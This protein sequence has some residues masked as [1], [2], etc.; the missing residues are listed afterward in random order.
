MKEIESDHIDMSV[1]SPPFESLYTYTPTERDL[2]NSKNRDEFIGH[3]KFI[4]TELLRITKPGRVAAVHVADIPAM[5][6]RDGYIGLKDFSG[7]VIRLFIEC[8][9]TFDSRIPIDKNQ[10]AQ[11]IRTHSKAL[12][13][14]QLEKDRTWNRPA[15]PDYILKFRKPGDNPVP[16][17]DKGV[18][19]D[20]WIELAN[21]TWP[22]KDDRAADAGAF[23]TWYGIDESDTLNYRGSRASEDERHI[24]P[25]QLGTIERCIRLW[26]NPGELVFTPFAG[27]FSEVYTAVKLGRRGLG[28]ELKPEYF[29]QGVKNMREF[30]EH[31]KQGAF[32][33]D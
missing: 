16:V 4:V 32:K 31:K 24:C 8:G 23:A 1:F 26:T 29:R 17:K 33:F 20:E 18:T 10:Q 22:G 19:R 13:M 14:S 27:V 28:V 7:D 25:L 15:L 2:G 30:E 3:F 5:L 12:T 21:P 11:S 6:V 9:W